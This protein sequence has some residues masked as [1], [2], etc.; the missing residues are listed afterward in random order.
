MVF[1]AYIHIC[2]H[3]YIHTCISLSLSLCLYTSCFPVLFRQAFLALN[4][5]QNKRLHGSRGCMLHAAV[6]RCCF[7]KPV[8]QVLP[9][10]AAAVAVKPPSILVLV[11][12]CLSVRRAVSLFVL[13][14][15]FILVCPCSVQCSFR[16]C[17]SLSC[18]APVCPC[19]VLG[20]LFD[21][22]L[23]GLCPCLSLPL[24]C[25][26]FFLVYPCTVL[27]SYL[28]VCSAVTSFDLTDVVMPFC[29]CFFLCPC[30]ST[31][32][33][34]DSLSLLPKVFFIELPLC[35]FLIFFFVHLKTFC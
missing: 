8:G 13:A 16:H 6:L 19:V 15:C 3:V 33:Y 4:I 18:W 17:L 22:G 9:P 27:S 31:L 25:G 1:H 5:M 24:R 14:A 32:S 28:P 29:P 7:P 11:C 20:S 12:P 30:F 21:F 35:F 2:I 23:L 26:Y 34:R 10:G